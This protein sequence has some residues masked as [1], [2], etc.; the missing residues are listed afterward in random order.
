MCSSDLAATVTVGSADDLLRDHELVENVVWTDRPTTGPV[1]V[2]CSAH[3]V[4]QPAT[5]GTFEP[6]TAAG[7]SGLFVRWD[8]PQRRIAPGQSAVFYTADNRSVL[9]GATVVASR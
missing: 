2:Q 4:A 9:G 6:D 7:G 8:T 3:G 5:V 1:L